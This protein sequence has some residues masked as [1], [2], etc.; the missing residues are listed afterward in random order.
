MSAWF[1]IAILGIPLIAISFRVL[2]RHKDLGSRNYLSHKSWGMT[3]GTSEAT[4]QVLALVI[5]WVGMVIG[6]VMVVAGVL[7]AGAY[8]AQSIF[9]A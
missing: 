4:H 1:A 7:K 6:L 8:L 5:G 9:G 3:M 2:R